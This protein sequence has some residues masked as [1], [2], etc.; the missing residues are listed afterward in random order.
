[1]RA[2]INKHWL[3]WDSPKV[4]LKRDRQKHGGIIRPTLIVIHYAVTHSLDYTVAA[5]AA[6]G[7]WAHLSI[8]GYADGGAQYQVYQALPFNEQGSHA[9][10]S[11]W[12]GRDRCNEFSIGI[13]IANPGPLVRDAQGALRTVYG[14]LWHEH[15]AL[16]APHSSL[17][18]N[19]AWQ[20]WARY[21]DQEF[22]ILVEVCR[23]LISEYPSID[24]I[25]GH[26]E[27]SPGRKFD[28][29]PAFDMDY[30]RSKTL[31]ARRP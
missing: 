28:P 14:K 24:S 27:I 8:D 23:A 31:D 25:A 11:S 2:R 16:K 13:E 15:D 19:H 29:G 17:P 1:M 5:Q 3:F 22:D 6:R 10:S 12:Q 18:K 9:G 26:D 7:Y 30:L 4:E 20:H 21:S